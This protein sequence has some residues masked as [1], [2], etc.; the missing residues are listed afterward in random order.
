MADEL[1]NI[2]VFIVNPFSKPSA[3]VD[4]CYAF[5]HLQRAYLRA[6]EEHKSA[7][8]NNIVLQI[9]PIDLVAARHGLVTPFQGEYIRLALEV[10][11]RCMPT[12][13]TS[14]TE[15]VRNK[16]VSLFPSSSWSS[17]TSMTKATSSAPTSVSSSSLREKTQKLLEQAIFSPSIVLAKP[18]PKSINFQLT[19]ESVT[20][21]THEGSCLHAAYKQSLDERWAVFAWTDNWGEH[22]LTELYPLGRKGCISLRQWEDVAREAWEKTMDIMRKWNVTR[23][24]LTK[25]TGLIDAAEVNCKF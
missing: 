14:T 21:L 3:M 4:L 10:Y 9:V 24:C 18:P 5:Y 8:P 12:D 19:P 11:N 2:V 23:I 6:M 16:K 17:K 13:N 15:E 20:A 25:A 7:Y 22:Q 1:Q